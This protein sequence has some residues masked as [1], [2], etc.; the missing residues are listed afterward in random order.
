[1]ET[2]DAFESSNISSLGYD[3]ESATLQVTFQNGTAYQY[4][5][6]PHHVWAAFKAAESKGV[7]LNTEI[8]GAYRYS[9]A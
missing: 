7:F 3:E 1:M 6:V 9:R 8:K 2:F 5:D 4:F